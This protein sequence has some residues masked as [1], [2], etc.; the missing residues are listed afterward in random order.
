MDPADLYLACVRMS[1]TILTGTCGSTA[2]SRC[3]V[4]STAQLIPSFSFTTMTDAK[5]SVH[6]PFRTPSATPNPTGSSSSITHDA[7]SSSSGPQGS[8]AVN[9]SALNPSNR[10]DEGAP[11]QP[12]ADEQRSVDGLAAELAATTLDEP[13]E[14]IEP[15]PAYTPSADMYQGEATVEYGPA[16]PFQPAPPPLAL[17]AYLSPHPTGG[18]YFVAPQFTGPTQAPIR[19]SVTG[20]WSNYPGQGGQGA[21]GPPPRHPS[22]RGRAGEPRIR[23]AER[24]L[25]EFARDFYTTTPEDGSTRRGPS[26]ARSN[27]SS[28]PEDAGPEHFERAGPPPAPRTN[29]APP[30]GPPP[31]IPNPPAAASSSSYAPP[32]G[33][34]PPP[35][36]ADA[37]NPTTVPTPG[38]P[39]LNKG[40]VLI[41]PSGHECRKCKYFMEDFFCYGLTSLSGMNTGYK[42]FDPTHPCRKCWDK[43]SKPYGGAIVYA[44]RS[45]GFQRPLPSFRP[46]HIRH[47]QTQSQPSLFSPPPG[48]PSPSPS[49]LRRSHS[50]NN[51]VYGPLSPIPPGVPRSPMGPGVGL[52]PPPPPI[53]PQPPAFRPQ[54]SYTRGPPPPGTAVVRPGDP[55]IGGRLC[56][57]C[58]GDGTVSF[59]IFDVETCPACGGVGRIL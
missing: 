49:R 8:S 3:S 44:P 5:R 57:R 21:F 37:S 34:P 53:P 50:S 25:S 38:R 59:L 32:S 41:Y 30:S 17:P 51:N 27:G 31:S 23:T 16:R 48:P 36:D 11:R 15:P 56:W 26:P 6:N 46:P 14:P 22:T 9:P 7:P 43:Y 13:P 18:S 20:N 35:R 4:S 42:G 28:G 45:P 1:D 24:P 33:P 10:S 55:R 52:S 2:E 47:Q 58:G 12:E 39:L 19:P 40:R 29:F 54:L